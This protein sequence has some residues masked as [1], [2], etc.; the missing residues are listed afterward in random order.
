MLLCK[1]FIPLYLESVTLYNIKMKKILFAL[2]AIIVIISCTRDE[3]PVSIQDDQ[4]IQAQK[5]TVIEAVLQKADDQIDKEI[6]MLEKLNYNSPTTKSGEVDLC[7]AKIAVETVAN[8]KFPK[9]ITLDYGKGCTDA[10]GNFRAGK[11]IVYITGP[12]WQKNTVRH[13]KLVDYIYNDLKISSERNEINSGQNDKGYF[14]FV[15]KH[16]EMISNTK[17]ELLVERVLDR[18]R[19]YN[20][21]KDLSSTNDDEVWINGIANVEKN[22]KNLVNKIT[23]PLYRKLT[24]QHFQS[25]VITTFVNT[26]QTAELNYGSGECDNTAIWTNGKVTKTITLQTSINYYSLKQ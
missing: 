23:T 16:S 26:K 5:E 3:S 1:S 11:I 4:F 8:T 22:G 20:R 18:V 10:V 14:V 25:G 17:G 9:T 19:T 15:V 21:G 12:Y 24:C 2:V 7:N 6:A 13:A